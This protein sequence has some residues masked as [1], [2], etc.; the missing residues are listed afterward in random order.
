MKFLKHSFIFKGLLLLSGCLGN[1]NPNYTPKKNYPYFITKESMIVKKVVVPK[2][3][4]LVYEEHFFKK[5]NQ[6]KMMI[7]EKLTS[8]ELPIGETIDWGGVPIISIRKFYN[9]EMRGFTVY[10]NFNKVNNHKKNKFLQLWKS[11]KCNLGITIKN[12]NDWS[13]N[14]G[15][16]SDVESC[17]VIYQRYFKEDANQQLVLD[18]LYDE[19]LKVG[20][21]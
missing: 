14:K 7:E 16:I 13:F 4:K 6:D 8:I 3:T 11:Y 21:N 5:G 17:G 19:L 15:N 9:Q 18:E 12:I 2:G 10:P 1:W 20:N